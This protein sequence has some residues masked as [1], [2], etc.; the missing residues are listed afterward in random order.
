[1]SAVE[2]ERAYTT[3]AHN[4]STRYTSVLHV[5]PLDDGRSRLTM[6]FEGTSSTT[7]GK[8]MTATVGRMLKSTTRKML[9]RD[10]DD[11]AAAAEASSR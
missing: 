5:E 8:L 10:L 9:Q 2:P 1:M 6:S 4:G 7:V 11:I 3:V